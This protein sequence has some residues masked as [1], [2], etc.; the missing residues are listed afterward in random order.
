[1]I[2]ILKSPAGSAAS[3]VSAVSPS[4][5]VVVSASAAAV[6]VSGAA[7]VAAG[8]AP[9]HQAMESTIAA[10]SV[11]LSNLFFITCLL[12]FILSAFTPNVSRISYSELRIQTTHK[13]RRYLI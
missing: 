11:R 6:V 5:A 2:P 1:M 3:V 10:A 4:A 12:L 8:S 9:R 13:I 7:V